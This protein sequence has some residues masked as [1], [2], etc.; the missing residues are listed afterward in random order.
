MQLYDCAYWAFVANRP[1]EAVEVFTGPGRWDLFASPWR[2]FGFTYFLF[3]GRAYHA[4]GRYEEEL[5]TYRRGRATYPV[6]WNG[7]DIGPLV[8]LGRLDE[9]TR[10][11]EGSP[12]PA[13]AALLVEATR[14]LGG[15]GHP[16]EARRMAVRCATRLREHPEEQ[17]ALKHETDERKALETVLLASEQW[18][19]AAS[20]LAGLERKARQPDPARMG[21]HAIAALRSGDLATASR[22]ERELQSLDRSYLLGAHLYWQAAL[23]AHRGEKER[24]V[25]LLRDALG[26]GTF[27]GYNGVSY[28]AHRSPELAP[29]FGTPP[30]EELVKPRG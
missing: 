26:E 22:I 15:H 2:P 18:K 13:T 23:A 11:I 5:A 14:E 3:L 1:A 17:E 28:W 9:V 8:A 21:F 4:L 6:M 24:A 25:A 12:G 10:L 30:F 19:E 7:Y 27:D 20:I 29:L 16:E